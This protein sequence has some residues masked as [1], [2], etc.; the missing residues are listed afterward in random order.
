[1]KRLCEEGVVQLVI[2]IGL[3]ALVFAG[4]ALVVMLEDRRVAKREAA[5]RSVQ[6][7]RLGEVDP[8][9]RGRLRGHG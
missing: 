6:L 1:M 8:L 2:V 3:V 7:A 9:A 4:A 5:R